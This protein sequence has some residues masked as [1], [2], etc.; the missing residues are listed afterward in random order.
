L[1]VA[2]ERR[3]A[4][5]DGLSGKGKASIRDMQRGNSGARFVAGMASPLTGSFQL[6]ANI[7]DS[8]YGGAV[9]GGK[10]IGAIDDDF[11]RSS[12]SDSVNKAI[13]EDQASAQR[14]QEAL[15]RGTFD[16]QGLV[17]AMSSGMGIMPTSLA[18]TLAGKTAQGAG[19][20]AVAAGT[21]PV[22]D[23]GN[24]GRSKALQTALGAGIG[25]VI[26][27]VAAAA[28]GGFNMARNTGPGRYVSDIFESA[29]T[30][31]RENA[32]RVL[33]EAV[34]GKNIEFANRLDNA[35]P[36]LTVDQAQLQKGTD[37]LYSGSRKL[38]G[39]G[40]YASEVDDPDVLGD[41][42]NK[43]FAESFSDMSSLGNPQKIDRLTA[44][45]DEVTAP[46]R[47]GAISAA[48]ET[49]QTAQ[50]LSERLSTL[51]R[52]ANDAVQDGG[53]L[54]AENSSA[55]AAALKASIPGVGKVPYRYAL[56]KPCWK[57]LN[58]LLMAQKQLKC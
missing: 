9:E 51:N 3:R 19:Y 36:G 50:R 1:R 29:T 58:P 22:I 45:R 46:M 16:A 48:D 13:S 10:M 55:R 4:A 47:E 20:G 37:G 26:P 41:I 5:E 25:G 21:Q 56:S 11:E 39:L 30:N 38:A 6:G 32:G 24:F 28:K 23:S 18:P 27:P 17:G 40:R 14:G 2:A 8:I 52:Q 43:Q 54:A 34:D 12:F 49:T 35:R 44:I 7:G 15:G 42:Y 57:T 31:A 33:T 53:R